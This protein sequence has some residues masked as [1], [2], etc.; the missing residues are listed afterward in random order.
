MLQQINLNGRQVKGLDFDLSYN[1][2]LGG[3]R[4]GM[5]ALATRMIDYIDTIGTNKT[6]GVGLFNAATNTALPKWRGNLQLPSDTDHF[7]LFVLE[8]YI[9]G[10]DQMPFIP[11]N[12][13]AQPHIT[14]V[15]YTDLT[16]K[17]KVQTGGSAFEIYGTVNNL[18]NRR[19]PFLPNRF[20]ANLAF[21]TVPGLYDLDNRYF[22][23]GVKAAF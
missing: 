15:F 18:F 2:K 3:G 1:G 20:A 22:T 16:V 14:S 6:Q 7:G 23:V 8:R 21:P 19:P 5:R 17:A 11:G 13:F 12:I 10:Y 9:G 4:F